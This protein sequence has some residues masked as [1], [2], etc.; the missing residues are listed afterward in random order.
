MKELAA[1]CTSDI[2]EQ[3]SAQP[4]QRAGHPEEQRVLVHRQPAVQ[5]HHAPGHQ[6]CGDPDNKQTNKHEAEILKQEEE[7]IL[8]DCEG[9]R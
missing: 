9:F 5:T 4:G 3:R 8:E 1:L 2:C 6:E 7:A